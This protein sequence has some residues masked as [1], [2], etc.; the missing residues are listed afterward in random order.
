M[1]FDPSHRE[2]SLVLGDESRPQSLPLPN[3]RPRRRR[4]VCQADP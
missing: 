3:T 1:A 2:Q 4:V